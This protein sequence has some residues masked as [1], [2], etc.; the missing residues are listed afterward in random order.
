MFARLT[1]S[2]AGLLFIPVLH[3]AEQGAPAGLP[4]ELPNEADFFAEQPIVLSVS[5]L[6]RPAAQSP[7]AVTVIDRAMIEASGFRQL[8]DVFR[9]VPGFQVG[10]VR[11]NL[12]VVT[13]QGLSS[14]YAR[15]MQVLVDGRSVYN[16]AYGQVHWRALPVALDDID[17]IEVV[18]GPNAANDG[19]NAF[20]ATIHI[21]TQHAALDRGTEAAL[22][23]GENGVLDGI[24]RHSGG[25]EDL[26]WRLTYLDRQDDWLDSRYYA[27]NDGAHE[28][29][30]NLRMDWQA[31]M[32]DTVTV[33][34]GYTLANWD[35]STVGYTFSP[36]QTTDFNSWYV[37]GSWHRVIDADSEISAQFHHTWTRGI[38]EFSIPS[39]LGLGP[40]SPD[41]L[42][43]WFQRDALELDVVQ[44]L[45]AT[46]RMTWGAEA[47]YEAA[48]SP[49]VT[50]KN[51]TLDGSTYRLSAA[52]EW[53]PA[54]EWLFHV[55]AMWE[56][57]Y[58][59]GDMLS[60]RLAVNW[61][62]V[63]GHSLRLATARAYRTPNILEQNADFKLTEAGFNLDQYLLSPY[64]LKPERITTRELGYVFQSAD[65]SLALDLRL[66]H[67]Q[68]EDIIDFTTPY[69]V[70]GELAGNGAD[71]TYAN[72]YRA[73]QRGG[74]Y[75]LRWKYAPEGWVSL[76][77]S[78][79]YTASDSTDYADSV[80][81]HSLGLL[82]ARELAGGW[83]TSLGYYRVGEMTWV[84]FGGP[85]PAHDRLDLRL[86]KHWK[87][88]G[89]RW[90]AAVTAQSVLGKVSEYG[91]SRYFDPRAF[92]TLRV[93]F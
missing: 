88:G 53:A 25:R 43:F 74:E 12:P 5:R 78:W 68:V 70:P 57:N 92:A 86:A 63:H 51:H 79:V 1:V 45:S 31:S 54:P 77:Q 19:A 16:P 56:R 26:S 21:Y 23:A 60:P 48:W 85:T 58:Y 13:Y 75:Q 82:T 50:G 3:A 83:N 41:N 66:F 73:T 84:G 15:R 39:K 27:Q 67:N 29:F 10:W 33:E 28:R 32:H 69:P 93:R 4:P 20:Q 76:W 59:G 42:N 62:P 8:A 61:Q 34:S 80:P 87:A 65:N 89:A 7:A 6:A 17:R 36:S 22:S 81:R 44:R 30:I 35:N 49:S 52:T 64:R 38:E 37:Q 24:V 46:L 9:L 71:L 40:V 14:L 18:R 55:G 11:G 47:R 2:L 91:P 72:L 90:E